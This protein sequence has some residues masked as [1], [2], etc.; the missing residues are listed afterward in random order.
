MFVY[1]YVFWLAAFVGW[2]GRVRNAVHL[3][4]I[5]FSILKSLVLA[6][7]NGVLLPLYQVTRSHDHMMPLRHVEA[8][9]Y[10]QTCIVN[11]KT[12]AAIVICCFLLSSASASFLNAVTES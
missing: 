5:F 10:N 7:C 6:I 9:K 1:S 2:A 8:R 4:L 3:G 12:M 11:L